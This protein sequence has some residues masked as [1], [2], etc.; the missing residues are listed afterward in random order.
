MDRE[1]LAGLFPVTTSAIRRLRRNL[2]IWW[3]GY[4]IFAAIDHLQKLGS[5][6]DEAVLALKGAYIYHVPHHAAGR[7]A[8]DD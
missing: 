7:R 3:A 6:A 8:V 1:A 5:E 4:H 2:A